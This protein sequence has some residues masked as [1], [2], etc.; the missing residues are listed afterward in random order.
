[1]IGREYAAFLAMPMRPAPYDELSA[2]IV[3]ALPPL[4][5]KAC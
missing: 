2:T 5:S 1:M 3:L 4:V